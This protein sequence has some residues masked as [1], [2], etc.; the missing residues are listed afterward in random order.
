MLQTVTI[1][2]GKVEPSTESSDVGRETAIA[3][4]QGALQ[5][6]SW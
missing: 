4:G 2:I 3:G 6:G 5:V 1:S